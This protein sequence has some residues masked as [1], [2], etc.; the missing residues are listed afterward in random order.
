M[1]QAPSGDAKSAVDDVVLEYAITRGPATQLIVRG[2]ELP[3][4]VRTRI[5]DRW[6]SALFDG[7]LERDARVIVRDHF[8]RKGYLQA[9]IT[10]AIVL[11]TSKELKTL[12]IEVAPGGMTPGRVEV[13]GNAE[14]T[15][16]RLVEVVN[17][18]DP[19]APWLDPRVCGAIARE[20]LPLR[21][22]SGRRRLARES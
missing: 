20:S 8:Y 22:V 15:T 11:D 4:D 18:A 17:A 14:L 12:T 16:A 9:T 21:R 2:T 19:L 10:A 5:A 3:D 7:F 13:T 1:T 6:S